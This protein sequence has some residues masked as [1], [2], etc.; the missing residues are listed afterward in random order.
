[1]EHEWSHPSVDAR[2]EVLAHPE[3]RRLIAELLATAPD[4]EVPVV[5]TTETDEKRL[6]I[7]MHHAHVPK[8]VERGVVER[9]ET[10]QHIRRGPAFD[11]IVPVYLTA[12]DSG[13]TAVAQWG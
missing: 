13:D 4:A 6:R 2:L 5:G 12:T 9:G 3:R 7:A 10:P 8:L 11:A 1:M